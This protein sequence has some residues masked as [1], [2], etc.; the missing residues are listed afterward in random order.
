MYQCMNCGQTFDSPKTVTDFYSEYWGAPA[1]HTTTVCPYCES[2]DF[3]EMDTCEICNEY[4]PPG[5]E[6]CDNCRELIHDIGDDIR[7]KSRYISLKYKLD[8]EKFISH[9]IDDLDR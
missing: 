2:D 9:L 1:R 8:Y 7:A 3:D 6:L 4:I 5:E